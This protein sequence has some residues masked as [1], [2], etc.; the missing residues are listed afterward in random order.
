MCS[1]EQKLGKDEV[2]MERDKNL[3][4]NWLNIP[5]LQIWT[6]IVL[7]AGELVKTGVRT[8][9]PSTLPG[10]TVKATT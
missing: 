8:D 10:G 1:K 4:Y 3:Q 5:L 9:T 6:G 2:S 7:T